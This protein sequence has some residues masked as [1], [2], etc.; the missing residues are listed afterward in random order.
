MMMNED[1]IAKLAFMWGIS[2]SASIALIV[3]LVR[4]RRSPFDTRTFLWRSVLAVIAIGGSGLAVVLVVSLDGYFAETLRW[5]RVL[6]ERDPLKV[7]FALVLG[8]GVGLS[9]VL[10]RPPTWWLGDDRKYRGTSA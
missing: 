5:L 1:S 9:I 2:V 6:F 3:A 4:W 8:S 7:S 10:A